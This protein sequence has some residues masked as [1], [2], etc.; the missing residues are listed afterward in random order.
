MADDIYQKLVNALCEI[1][2][3]P[4]IKV[5]TFKK[6]ALG[7]AEAEFDTNNGYQIRVTEGCSR[8]TVVHEWT[9]YCIHL[10]TRVEALEE[11]L[12]DAVFAGIES[13]ADALY[14]L[15]EKALNDIPKEIDD[16]ESEGEGSP[17]IV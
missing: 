8:E 5:H 12:C 1:Y 10:I 11:S 17:E 15:L 7:N 2:A 3:V 14:P 16:S 6:G 9:H 13:D 4:S